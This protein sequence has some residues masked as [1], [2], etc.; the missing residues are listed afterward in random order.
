MIADLDGEDLSGRNRFQLAR[1]M[2]SPL[3]DLR[4][5]AHY[6]PVDV[7]DGHLI[8]VP[9]ARRLPRLEKWIF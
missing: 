4:K 6:F 2:T 9:C 8:M 3:L 1:K 7:N 5:C